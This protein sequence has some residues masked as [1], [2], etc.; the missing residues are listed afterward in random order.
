MPNGTNTGLDME[1]R[2]HIYVSKS[3]PIVNMENKNLLST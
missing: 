3:M 1:T 2:A